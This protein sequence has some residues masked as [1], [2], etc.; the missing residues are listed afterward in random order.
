MHCEAR[1][2]T[3]SEAQSLNE[4][5]VQVFRS[6]GCEVLNGRNVVEIDTFLGKVERSSLIRWA[7]YILQVADHL[8]PDRP[9]GFTRFHCLVACF[10]DHL[11]RQRA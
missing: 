3:D 8:V 9:V 2:A 4:I 6:A 7:R 1:D 11:E 5:I 10:V